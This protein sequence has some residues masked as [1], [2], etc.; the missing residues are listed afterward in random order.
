[1]NTQFLL[2]SSDY[3]HEASRV[4]WFKSSLF[5]L[6]PFL[7]KIQAL[8]TFETRTVSSAYFLQ[9]TQ[10]FMHNIHMAS[11]N[12]QLSN[13]SYVPITTEQV[14]PQFLPTAYSSTPYSALPMHDLATIVSEHMYPHH[15]FTFQHGT[16]YHRLWPLPHYLSGFP[17]Y[18]WPK[19]HN[20][21]VHLCLSNWTI[22]P[23]SQASHCFYSI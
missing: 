16:T 23:V 13:R 21:S 18:F 15:P 11:N 4:P 7:Q 19:N 10:Y 22:R 8:P 20:Q 14:R 17:G 5:F 9:S 1:M 3:N 6:L 12:T 2:P